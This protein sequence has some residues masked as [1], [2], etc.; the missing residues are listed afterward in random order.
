MALL[1]LII[2]ILLLC[3]GGYWGYRAGYPARPYGG[4]LVFVLLI[5]ILLLLFGPLDGYPWHHYYHW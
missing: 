3:G 2:L 4:L 1:L 5:V